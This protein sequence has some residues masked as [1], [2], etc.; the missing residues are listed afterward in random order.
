MNADAALVNKEILQLLGERPQAELVNPDVLRDWG[1][2]FEFAGNIVGMTPAINTFD[3]AVNQFSDMVEALARL[4]NNPQPTP[5][6]VTP[7]PNWDAS[8][9]P[10][11]YAMYRTFEVNA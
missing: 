3:G 9:V 6:P 8:L 2:L 1:P 7:T 4:L 5:A 11:N 10:Q